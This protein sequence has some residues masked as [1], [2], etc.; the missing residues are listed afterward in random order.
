M[1]NKTV[2]DDLVL[3]ADLTAVPA[4]VGLPEPPCGPQADT[5]CH[6]SGSQWTV[7][8]STALFE[9]S[10]AMTLENSPAQ[11]STAVTLF[12]RA[13]GRMTTLQRIDDQIAALMDQRKKVLDEL[14]QVQVQINE[15][16]DRVMRTNVDGAGQL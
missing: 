2:S 4:V 11:S 1:G 10:L 12:Q 3:R 13:H 7:D 15:E 9:G 6:P 16:F 14:R 5:A 8:G